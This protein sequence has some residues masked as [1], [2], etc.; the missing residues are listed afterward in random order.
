MSLSPS[1]QNEMAVAERHCQQQR[2]LVILALAHGERLLQQP[3][4][5]QSLDD[6]ECLMAQG[7]ASPS[8]SIFTLPANTSA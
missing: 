3:L 8:S 1:D 7:R 2:L 4:G 6:A 5:A